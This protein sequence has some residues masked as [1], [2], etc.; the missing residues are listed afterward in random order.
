MVG[1][2][3]VQIVFNDSVDGGSSLLSLFSISVCEWSV[4]LPQSCQLF[5]SKVHWT[6]SP[7]SGLGPVR[8]FL[9][10]SRCLDLPVNMLLG[11][12]LLTALPNICTQSP[13]ASS[14]WV[15]SLSLPLSHP[16][17]SLSLPT[18]FPYAP[19]KLPVANNRDPAWC[20]MWRVD[21]C[22]TGR[23]SVIMKNRWR[24]PAGTGQEA[25]TGQILIFELCRPQGWFFPSS[26]SFSSYLFLFL[27]CTAGS[28]P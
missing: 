26:S 5:I 6:Q 24:D 14:L 16:P 15:S 7:Q 23:H 1:G 21:H 8:S 3:F 11:S 25:L 4:I 22:V 18:P 13:A 20:G 19:H 27:T 12:C 2:G 28:Q 17:P 10:S 9:R